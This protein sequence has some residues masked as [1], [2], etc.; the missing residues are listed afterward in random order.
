[1]DTREAELVR[2]VQVAQLRRQEAYERGRMTFFEQWDV[3]QAVAD[4]QKDLLRYVES[5]D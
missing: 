1:M 5:K 4:A 3:D 2:E